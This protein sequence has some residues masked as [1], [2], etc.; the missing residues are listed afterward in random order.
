MLPDISWRSILRL[1]SAIRSRASYG[2]LG[3]DA[4]ADGTV[5]VCVG[6]QRLEPFSGK[7]TYFLEY[8]YELKKESGGWKITNVGQ[9]DDCQG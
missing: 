4:R 7:W 1:P 3:I 9:Y 8:K 2:I 6:Y 5:D